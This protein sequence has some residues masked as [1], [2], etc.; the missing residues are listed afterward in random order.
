MSQRSLASFII[1]KKN[2]AFFVV[3]KNETMRYAFTWL[4][5]FPGVSSALEAIRDVAGQDV[6]VS[7]HYSA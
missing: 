1:Q 5:H 4:E 2:G 3:E 6:L 7:F